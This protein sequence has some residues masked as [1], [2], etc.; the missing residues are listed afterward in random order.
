M[1]A[2]KKRLASSGKRRFRVRCVWSR[3]EAGG[4]EKRGRERKSR[5]VSSKEGGR[6][7]RDLPYEIPTTILPLRAGALPRS[8]FGN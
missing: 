5:E 1:H 6:E 8:F 2:E 7:E 3:S 4:E